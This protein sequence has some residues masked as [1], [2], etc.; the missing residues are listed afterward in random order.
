ML[1]VRHWTKQL[2]DGIL[3]RVCWEE[4]GF[5]ELKAAQRSFFP[6]LNFLVAVHYGSPSGGGGWHN[7]YNLERNPDTFM[8]TV[9]HTSP[10]KF[11]CE[12][13]AVSHDLRRSAILLYSAPI[14]PH[15]LIMFVNFSKRLTRIPP[16][17]HTE[18]YTSQQNE[19]CGTWRRVQGAQR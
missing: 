12:R 18:V 19:W 6:P 5:L 11:S 7:L 9:I 10:L 1:D 8:R 4:T 16:P 17:R 2:F 14:T 3:R 13:H 15:C